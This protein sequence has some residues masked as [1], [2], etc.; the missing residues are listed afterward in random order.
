MIAPESCAAI[1]WRD[2]G[3]APQAAA[4]L[5]LTATDL[6]QMKIID[7]IIPEPAEGAQMDTA[8]AVSA[9]GDTL[10]AALTELRPLPP[11][12][13]ISQRYEKFRNMG[14]FFGLA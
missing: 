3:Q 11:D 13:V 14:N 10:R 8:A 4:A 7:G 2:S 6:L 9:A 1:I 5:K 12:Q